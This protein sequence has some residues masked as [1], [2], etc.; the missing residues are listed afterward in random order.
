MYIP[1][2]QQVAVLPNI[3]CS[4][5][6]LQTYVLLN[7][8]LVFAFW[9]KHFLKVNEKPTN[10]LTIQCIG[11]QYSS[12]CFGILKYHHQ[13]VK[14]DPAEIIIITGSGE[15]YRMRSLL[16]CTPHQMLLTNQE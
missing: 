12:T 9:T 8:I 3:V 6:V 4:S 7:D 5:L 2:Q 16:I 15:D 14:H 13:G 11:S 10:A 1:H